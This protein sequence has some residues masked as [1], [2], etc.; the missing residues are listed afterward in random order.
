MGCP[1]GGTIKP[2]TEKYTRYVTSN[3][4]ANPS[5]NLRLFFSTI[6]KDR[7]DRSAEYFLPKILAK[8]VDN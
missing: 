2:K 4:P 7:R 1:F 8:Q 6:G 3:I 5:E